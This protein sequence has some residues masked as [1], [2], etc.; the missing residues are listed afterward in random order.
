MTEVTMQT[1][2]I[3]YPGRSFICSFEEARE[4]VEKNLTSACA[5]CLEDIMTKNLTSMIW[6]KTNQRREKV[7]HYEAERKLLVVYYKMD[8]W[9]LIEIIDKNLPTSTVL[10][11]NSGIVEFY[12][13]GNKSIGVSFEDIEEEKDVFI[14]NIFVNGEYINIPGYG[15]LKNPMP[16]EV[17][18]NLMHEWNKF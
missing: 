8:E 2:Y 7:A 9:D 17:L 15:T 14:Y 18:Y 13:E 11:K 12:V 5:V 4:Y 10:E 1:P 3:Q 16:R 6:Y